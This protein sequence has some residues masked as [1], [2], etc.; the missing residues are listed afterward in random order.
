MTEHW[1]KAAR[2]DPR[3]V[4]HYVPIS[5]RGAWSLL[6]S[7]CGSIASGHVYLQPWKSEIRHI[8]DRPT[9]GKFC[10][11]CLAAADREVM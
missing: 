10:E 4:W 6:R 2:K 3:I 8:G 5:E 1:F 9:E 11:R 7:P